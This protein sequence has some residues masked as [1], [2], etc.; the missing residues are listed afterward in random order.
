MTKRSNLN[1]IDR[2]QFPW[3]TASILYL[4]TYE[5]TSAVC[6]GTEELHILDERMQTLEASN[7]FK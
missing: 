2:L 1:L 5:Q 7:T 3:L 4:Q 6:T